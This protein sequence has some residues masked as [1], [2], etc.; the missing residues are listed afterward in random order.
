MKLTRRLVLAAL[1]FNVSFR[2]NHI[3]GKQNVIVDQLSRF[4]FQKAR[5]VIIALISSSS[6][7]WKLVFLMT[8]IEQLQS[9][10]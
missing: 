5:S 8:L 10:F 1:K 6:S 9:T 7:Y 2:A 3:A 4:Q